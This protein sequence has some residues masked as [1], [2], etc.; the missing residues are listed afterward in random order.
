MRRPRPSMQSPLD[1]SRAGS[2]GR[3]WGCQRCSPPPRG[4]AH[5]LLASSPVGATLAPA[6][7]TGAS[8]HP[9]RLWRGASG[10]PEPPAGP[11]GC[12]GDR[13]TDRSRPGG[14]PAPQPGGSEAHPPSVLGSEPS[15]SA[16]LPAASVLGTGPDSQ[17]VA[18]SPG[19]PAISG[20]RSVT[21]AGSGR[22]AVPLTAGG[23]SDHRCHFDLPPPFLPPLPPLPLL[24]PPLP[25]RVSSRGMRSHS[26]PAW[27]WSRHLE[28]W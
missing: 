7:A 13:W 1:S 23:G 27:V 22:A 26:A 21:S 25:P 19:F 15:G 10:I 18:S 12:S 4:V 11:T 17:A 14:H 6:T 8:W 24:L 9:R 5:P 16:R 3:G 20:C 28:H 2:R